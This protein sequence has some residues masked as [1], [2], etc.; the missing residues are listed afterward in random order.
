M[1]NSEYTLKEEPTDFLETKCGR[2]MTLRGFFPD[3][4]ARMG[5]PLTAAGRML[6][7][8]CTVDS[9]SSVGTC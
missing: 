5:F 9:R 4:A 2:E 3:Q 8:V 6:G 1:T 7:Y